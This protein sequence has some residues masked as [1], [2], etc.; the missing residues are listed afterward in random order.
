MGS[1]YGAHMPSPEEIRRMAELIR[2][3][4]L[5]EMQGKHRQ[6]DLMRPRASRP[7]RVRLSRARKGLSE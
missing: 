4:K 5:A 6:R 2:S 3:E 1:P 7:V